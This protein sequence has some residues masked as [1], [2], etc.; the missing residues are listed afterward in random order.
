MIRESFSH[1]NYL[2][3][4]FISNINFFFSSSKIRSSGI[5]FYAFTILKIYTNIHSFK[6]NRIYIENFY[7]FLYN[8][9]G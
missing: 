7:F 2:L 5:I 9:S 6:K 1:V 3:E 8:K 4:K